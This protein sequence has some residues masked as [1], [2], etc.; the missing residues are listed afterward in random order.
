MTRWMSSHLGRQGLQVGC[1]DQHTADS[2]GLHRS[3]R[4]LL[5]LVEGFHKVGRVDVHIELP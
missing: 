4:P 2:L 3:I 5:A 1:H